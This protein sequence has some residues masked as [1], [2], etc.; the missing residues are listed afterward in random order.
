MKFQK[1]QIYELRN[2]KAPCIDKELYKDN[3]DEKFIGV[4]R[5]NKW[6][7]SMYDRNY[8]VYPIKQEGK[9]KK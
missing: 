3:E 8:Y 2:L 5:V 9:N 6:I 1:N 4:Y 7:V